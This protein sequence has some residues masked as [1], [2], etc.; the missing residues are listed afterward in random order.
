M[1]PRTRLRLRTMTVLIIAIAMVTSLAVFLT[2]S[3]GGPHPQLTPMSYSYSFA[4]NY[5]HRVRSYLLHVPPAAASGKPLP[6]VLNLAGATQNGLLEEL[7]TGMDG[8]A[9]KDG[10]LVAY[11]NGTRISTVLTRIRWPSRPSTAG[12]PGSAAVFL[13]PTRSTMSD[14][15]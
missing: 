3:S 15:C 14:S 4:V 11:P 7:Q 8:S 1:A 12:T 2:S 13:S 6:L 5:G 9:D 10:Y